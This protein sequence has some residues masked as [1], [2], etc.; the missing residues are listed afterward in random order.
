MQVAGSCRGQE[1][2]VCR[3]GRREVGRFVA[4]IGRIEI[5]EAAAA[6]V[7]GILAVDFV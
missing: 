6:A 2:F 7:E 3:A 1:Y 4:D 5:V